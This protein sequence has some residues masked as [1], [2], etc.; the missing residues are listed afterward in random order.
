ME[1]LTFVG[2]DKLKLTL[3][4]V[5]PLTNAAEVH[6]LLQARQTKGKLVLIP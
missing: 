4:V 1:L 3:G 5:F 6:R 2:E